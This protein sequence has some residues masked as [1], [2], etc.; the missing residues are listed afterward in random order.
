MDKLSS[1][2]EE[3][4]IK[5]TNNKE[6]QRRIQETLTK[7]Q[8]R[9]KKELFQKELGI[10]IGRIKETYQVKVDTKEPLV[11]DILIGA[12]GAVGGIFEDSVNLAKTSSGTAGDD[13]KYIY[14]GMMSS[15][16][17][18]ESFSKS[19]KFMGTAAIASIGVGT[20]LAVVAPS[21][22]V[23]LSSSMAL[24]S[25]LG[26]FLMFL[27][28]IFVAYFI[29]YNVI[30]PIYEAGVTVAGYIKDTA[31]M[32]I[33]EVVRLIKELVTMVVEAIS[34]YVVTPIVEASITVGNEIVNLTRTLQPIPGQIIDA[35]NP[36]FD[37][38]NGIIDP[39]SDVAFEIRYTIEQALDIV[40]GPIGQILDRIE[41]VKELADKLLGFV[42]GLIPSPGLDLDLD[43]GPVKI[44]GTVHGVK[45]S[46]P[47]GW[48][49]YRCMPEVDPVTGALDWDSIIDRNFAEVNL[50]FPG[51]SAIESVVKAATFGQA[52][53]DFDS[54]KI[55]YYKMCNKCD[56]LMW[57]IRTNKLNQL[58]DMLNNPFN[59][60]SIIGD[61]LKQPC[62]SNTGGLIPCK[63]DLSL[64]TIDVSSVI[65]TAFGGVFGSLF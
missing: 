5:L 41:V 18:G 58:A 47:C 39:I 43:V 45:G 40:S 37:N 53:L 6:I 8:N 26:G 17:M 24:V 50:K 54:V 65:N 52:D 15:P 55:P 9:I 33:K 2:I 3:A 35:L 38:V 61:T 20:G 1:K 4:N 11:G 25:I 23:A 19:L 29:Y 32:I 49:T 51:D 21:V 60:V 59:I 22:L 30:T 27:S 13:A 46:W 16:I 12:A 57:A 10:L 64:F 48:S 56:L 14:G 63:L 7:D 34:T 44:G 31:E 28:I 42:S 36:I 62:M